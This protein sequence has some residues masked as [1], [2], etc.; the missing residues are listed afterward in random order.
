MF[1][2]ICLLISNENENY[3]MKI[4]NMFTYLNEIRNENEFHGAC[5]ILGFI[6]GVTIPKGLGIR[7]PFL[8]PTKIPSTKFSNPNLS[9]IEIQKYKMKKRE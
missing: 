1:L 9:S 3:K 4:N 2:M 8:E 6:I 5:T 7:T